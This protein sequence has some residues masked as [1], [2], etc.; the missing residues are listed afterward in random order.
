MKNLKTFGRQHQVNVLGESRITM[1]HQ[2]DCADD[3]VIN[4]V[5][6][7]VLR[8]ARQ[9]IVQC[10]LAHKIPQPFGVLSM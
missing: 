7:E 1:S 4:S 9:N 6:V 5:L 8:E 10:T 2:S 3:H